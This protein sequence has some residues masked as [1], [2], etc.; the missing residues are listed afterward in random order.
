MVTKPSHR[1]WRVL[2]SEYLSHEPWYTVRRERVELPSGAVVPNWYIFE[3][4]TWVNVIARTEEGQFLMIS[5]YRHALGET[6]YELV[7]GCCDAGETPLEAA[8]RELMEE[9]G[10]GGGEWRELMALS[11]N[12][13][14]H[15]NRSYTFV[16]EGVKRLD[17]QHAEDTEDIDIHLMSEEEV[18][19]LLAEDQIIQ[20]LH[21][22][23]LWKY[24]FESQIR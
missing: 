12:P 23:P 22:A 8:R 3:F 7:A 9:T 13:T 11:P 4:P 2:A 15:T 6:R 20:A 14:N 1:P 10:Y 17:V 5:Q 18:R 16:A 19:E 21:A 24:L